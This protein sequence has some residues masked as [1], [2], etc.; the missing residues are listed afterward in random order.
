MHDDD[1]TRRD[2]TTT[3]TTCIIEGEASKHCPI[4]KTITKK[5]EFDTHSLLSASLEFSLRRVSFVLVCE[6]LNFIMSESTKQVRRV[7]SDY[8]FSIF[9]S[10][11]FRLFLINYRFLSLPKMPIVVIMVR[12][13]SLVLL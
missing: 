7:R 6:K 4:M 10:L 13:S 8:G 2:E 9:A 1:E 3:T 12:D 5:E 11:T